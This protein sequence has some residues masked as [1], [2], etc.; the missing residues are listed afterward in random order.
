M[1]ETKRNREKGTDGRKD[2]EK[3]KTNT[4]SPILKT[5]N[6]GGVKKKQSRTLMHIIL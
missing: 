1:S 4:K 5:Q 3:E 6:L 2:A